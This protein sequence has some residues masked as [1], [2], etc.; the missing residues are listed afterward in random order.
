MPCRASVCNSVLH[1]YCS[2]L[3]N[4]NCA[5]RIYSS[6][7]GSI[8]MEGMT[9]TVAVRVLEE[10]LS[11]KRV[12][13]DIFLSFLD[14]LDGNNDVMLRVCVHE[15]NANASAVYFDG[16]RGGATDGSQLT[17]DAALLCVQETKVSHI[18]KYATAKEPPVCFLQPFLHHGQHH[19][20]L[21]R[22]HL[23]GIWLPVVKLSELPSIEAVSSLV[24]LHIGRVYRMTHT[25]SVRQHNH[26]ASGLPHEIAHDNTFRLTGSADFMIR[27]RKRFV[28][29][30][31]HDV[32]C[33]ASHMRHGDAE[34]LVYAWKHHCCCSANSSCMF[35]PN[36]TQN[37]GRNAAWH[38]TFVRWPGTVFTYYV[39]LDGD[40][41]LTFRPERSSLPAVD[42]VSI[43]ELP[44]RMFEQHLLHYSPAVGFPYYSGWHHDNGEEVQF[45]SNY[46]HIM[47]AIHHNV[48]RFFLPTE[49]RFDD[50]S[51]WYGQRIHGFLAAVAF[52]NQTLQ[53]N[54]VVSDNGSTGKR[55][56]QLNGSKAHACTEESSGG[57]SC[58][59]QDVEEVAASKPCAYD[60]SLY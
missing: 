57:C 54:A 51:W 26:G 2:C 24:A 14:Y 10:T 60:L 59:A 19:V 41:S 20:A 45:V 1:A 55:F 5:C 22:F 35:F 32:F 11:T 13:E 7:S 34:V 25:L 38:H 47:I 9:L 12:E 4:D 39:F 18:F 52:G 56:A 23:E 58:R 6:V 31:Q 17:D 8:E 48:S 29:I 43:E 15:T 37:E 36:S 27:N 21:C 30:V 50:V 40:M 49:T 3:L 53:L 33:N 42:G 28:Y 46:D 44:F 16:T